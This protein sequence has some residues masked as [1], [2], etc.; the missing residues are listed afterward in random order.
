MARAAAGKDSFVDVRTEMRI[1]L[2]WRALI[3]DFEYIRYNPED[4]L[5]WYMALELRGPIEIRELI[6]ER[7]SSRPMP[8]I[9][10]VVNK[11]PHPPTRLVREWL[12]YHEQQ[13]RTGAYWY[14]PVGFC[15]FCGLLFPFLYSC[16][17]LQPMNPLVMHPPNNGIQ[18]PQSVANSPNYGASPSMLPPITGGPTGTVTLPPNG[19]NTGGVAPTAAPTAG[20]TGPT[21]IGAS[22]AASGPP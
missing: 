20:V 1:A 5:R 22:G 12:S 9:H 14:A 10:G 4:M 13:V 16:Q 18:A 11:A 2:F 8:V 6:T 3:G 15:L 7:Y 17:Y 19:G 21:N